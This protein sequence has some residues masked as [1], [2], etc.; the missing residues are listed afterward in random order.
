MLPVM[1]NL[2]GRVVVVVGGGAVGQRKA[3]AAREAGAVVRV[4]D[5][6]PAG[7]EEPGVEWV[8][9]VYRATHLVGAGLVFACGPPDVNAQVVAD[10]TARGIWVNSATSPSEGDFVLPAAARRGGITLAVSTGGASPALA[11]RIRDKLEAEIDPALVE[12][13][14]LLD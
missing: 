12:W 8:A 6:K 5:P 13:V 14:A 11:R 9:D 10:A 7:A 3:A 2:A 4:I 1:L